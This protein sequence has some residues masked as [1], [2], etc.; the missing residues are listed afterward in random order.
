MR[1]TSAAAAACLALASPALAQADLCLTL[2]GTITSPAPALV[3]AIRDPAA[4]IAA[5][6]AAVQEAPGQGLPAI[7][8]ARALLAADPDDP[9][10]L[11]LLSGARE[12]AQP[13]ADWMIG[14]LYEYG[15]AGLPPSERQARDLY[16]ATCTTGGGATDAAPACAALALMQI[17]ERGGPADETGGFT[18]LR[19]LCDDGFGP[20]CTESAFQGELRGDAR[21]EDLAA[22]LAQGCAAGDLLGCSQ[23]AF[24]L[25]LGEGVAPDI[26]AARALYDLACEGGEPTGCTGLGEV[27]RSGLGVRPD[28]AAAVRYFDLGCAGHDSYACVTLGDM[29]A[30]GRGVPVDRPRAQALFDQACALG[31]PEGCDL[32]DTLR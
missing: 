19:T 2:S 26:A 6:R 16:A 24:R 14:Q 12:T 9:E 13:L 20:A 7:L 11:P 27:Y 3:H 23:Y 22:L 1:L 25:E 29:L 10:V 15:L 28:M 32:A 30:N 31:D 4:T 17:E 21:P 5:C 8:L 18:L